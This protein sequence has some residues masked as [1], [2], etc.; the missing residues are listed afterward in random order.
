MGGCKHL[1]DVKNDRVAVDEIPHQLMGGL[2]T[3]LRRILSMGIVHFVKLSFLGGALK[4]GSGFLKVSLHHQKRVG[5]NSKQ[6]IKPPISSEGLPL[7]FGTHELR[8]T[9]ASTR[10][11][12]RDHIRLRFHKQTL[13]LKSA[14]GERDQARKKKASIKR[15]LRHGTH[16]DGWRT[17]RG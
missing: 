6:K 11:R 12:A 4:T 5:T 15:R 1:Q 17:G 3:V 14:R 13:P 9:F 16:V 7:R 8:L 2:S 10:F